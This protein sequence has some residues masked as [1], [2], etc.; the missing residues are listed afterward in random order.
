MQPFTYSTRKKQVTVR[1]YYEVP[2]DVLMDPDE[3][4]LWARQAINFAA[5]RRA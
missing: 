1:R 4:R 2:E 3:L 5:G